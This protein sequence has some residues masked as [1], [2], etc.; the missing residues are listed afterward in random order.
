[1]EEKLHQIKNSAIPLILEADSEKEL[2]EVYLQF[3]GKSGIFTTAVKE[4]AKLPKE[5]RPVAGKIANEVKN[6]LENAITE[7]KQS[8]HIST[9]KKIQSFDVTDPGILPP[10]GHLHLTTQGIEEITT[11]FERIG[12]TRVRYPEVEWDWYAFEA[13]NFP[14]NHPARDDWETFFIDATPDPKKG[15][16]LLTPHTSSGQIRQME[17]GELPIRMLNI[18]KC[19]RRQSDVSHAA[20]FHQFEGLVVDKGINITHLKGTL[21]YFVKAWFGKDRVS[22][23]RPYQFQFTEPSFEVDVS[24]GVCKGKGILPNGEKCRLCKAGWL[25]MGGSGMVHPNVLKN[26][27]IDPEVYTGFAFGWGVERVIMMKEGL[28][29]D[30]LRLL[31]ANNIEFLEQ[32]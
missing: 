22:R 8:L 6:A 19:Y 7:K 2:E 32:F 16:M 28:E 25:E 24:C 27:G 30:D 4:L 11:I 14:E 17:K 26:C 31:Y 23:I 12:F 21:D 5:V 20:M 3:L 10:L 18:A 15:P 1:M 9:K 13:L 29:I